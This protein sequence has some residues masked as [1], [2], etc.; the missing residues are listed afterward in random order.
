M[1]NGSKIEIHLAPMEGVVDPLTR[2]VLSSVG[3][4]DMMSTEFVRV[5]QNLV[6]DKIFYEF[7]PELKNGGRTKYGTPVK[8]QLLGSDT[9]LMGENAQK[10]CALGAMG[11]DLNFGCPAKSV[12]KNDGGATLLKNP[13]RVFHVVSAVRKHTPLHIPVS[14]K[15][16]LGFDHKEFHKEIALAAEAGG[17]ETLTIHAR[18]KAEG[19]A[20]PAHWEYIALMKEVVKI[21]V[22]ANGDIWNLDE[23]Q[24]CR[25]ITGCKAFALGRA[26]MATP[27]LA[28]MIH[29]FEMQESNIDQ[30]NETK[31]EI[32]IETFNIL[33]NYIQKAQALYGPSYTLRRTKQ[34][35]KLLKHQHPWSDELFDKV[36]V[37][38][39]T[40]ADVQ[41]ALQIFKQQM[42]I[43]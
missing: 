40:E 4:F 1:P 37:Y 18:T 5:S 20:P 23:F 11:I 35:L 15:V 34:W 13:E 14:A 32:K 26:A 17:A 41:S 29:Q 27:T 19:Y 21:K 33:M 39:E 24:R 28:K 7:C 38:K 42:L 8:V 6:P 9:Q 2:E 22:V 31:N 43:I 30:Q 10:V 12:N 36:K 3:G 25:E 16:R